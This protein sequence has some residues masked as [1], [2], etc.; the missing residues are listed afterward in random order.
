ML[1]HASHAAAAGYKAVIITSEDTDVFVLSLA[2]K[3]FIPCSVFVKCG[4]DSNN[5]HR[6]VKCCSDVG[7]RTMLISPRSPCLQWLRQRQCFLWKDQGISFEDGETKQVLPN[8]ISGNRYRVEHHIIITVIII[9]INM[10][11]THP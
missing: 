2:F 10:A 5:I 11:V 8:F 9:I 1:L 4:Q 7:P 6:C 3:G